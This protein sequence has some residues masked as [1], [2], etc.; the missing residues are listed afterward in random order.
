[1]GWGGV[2][3]QVSLYDGSGALAASAGGLSYALFFY[4]PKVEAFYAHALPPMAPDDERAASFV[5]ARVKAGEP[6]LLDVR[7]QPR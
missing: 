4:S 2:K 7:T 1:M 6:A 5:R 3:R